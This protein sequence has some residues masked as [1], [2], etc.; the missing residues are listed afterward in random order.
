MHRNTLLHIIEG[1]VFDRLFRV[2]CAEEKIALARVSKVC[3]KRV[4]AGVVRLSLSLDQ[5][6]DETPLRFPAVELLQI[7][8]VLIDEIT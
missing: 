3:K 2:L 6:T 5:T 7:C 4:E 8:G 1:D